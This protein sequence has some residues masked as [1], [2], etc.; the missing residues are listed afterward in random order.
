LT[1]LD[2]TAILIQAQRP[3]LPFGRDKSFSLSGDTNMKTNDLKKGD[4]VHLNNG[5]YA[6]IE[7]NKK[8]NIRTATVEGYYT[9]KGSI[10]AYDILTFITP[11]GKRVNIEHTPAQRKVQRLNQ[12]RKEINARLGF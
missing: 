3:A 12:G 1:I 9:E 6:T 5:W 4:R 8:G 2:Q 7:D 10:Y 11:E